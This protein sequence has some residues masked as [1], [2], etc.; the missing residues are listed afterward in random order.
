MP[1]AAV[2]TVNGFASPPLQIVCV[3]ES[4]PADTVFTITVSTLLFTIQLIPFNI[5]VVITR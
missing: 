5:L 2:T 1:V 4:V 3:W